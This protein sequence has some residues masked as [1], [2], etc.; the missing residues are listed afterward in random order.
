M[1]VGRLP[2]LVGSRFVGSLS[3]IISGLSTIINGLPMEISGLF[4]KIRVRFPRFPSY[5]RVIVYGYK[6]NSFLY[7]WRVSLSP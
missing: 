1:C 2:S 5:T 6:K 4:T 7:Y 3:T